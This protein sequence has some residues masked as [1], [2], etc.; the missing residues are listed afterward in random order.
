VGSDRNYEIPFPLFVLRQTSGEEEQS[1]CH[2]LLPNRSGTEDGKLLANLSTEKL[3][4][5]S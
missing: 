1:Y 4:G 2:V 3:G 5:K